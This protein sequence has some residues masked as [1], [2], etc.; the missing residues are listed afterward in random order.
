M[1]AAR[2]AGWLFF[3]LIALASLGLYFASSTPIPRLDDKTLSLTADTIITNV[4]VR[5]FDATGKM[6]NYLHTPEIQHIPDNNI[7][8]LKLPQIALW[9]DNQP[10]WK[11][12]SRQAKAINGGEQITFMHQVVIHQDKSAHSQESTMKTEKLIYLSKEKIAHTDL[13]V[14]FEQ[15]GTIVYSKGMKAYLVDKRIQLLS[16]ARATFEPK[17]A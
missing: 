2:H 12:S 1:N 14:R 10:G 9:Q 11:I 15:P 4:S 5:K 6:V 7:Y 17:H 3:A 13:T 16:R 8:L